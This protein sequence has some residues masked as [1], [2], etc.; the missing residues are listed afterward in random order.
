MRDGT[1]QFRFTQNHS[2]K[3]NLSEF[4]MPVNEGSIVGNACIHEISI[5]IPDIYRLSVNPSE[6]PYAARHD[7][8]WDQ[9]IGY[10]TH[11]MLTVPM[12][13]IS[14]NV[15]GVIQ[16]INRKKDKATRGC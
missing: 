8:T 5:N 13:D 15:I 14:H 1:I 6:N 11:S 2:I 7:R 16:L 10:E 4:S 3:Q 9:R 12:F